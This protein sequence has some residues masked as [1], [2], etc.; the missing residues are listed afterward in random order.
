LLYLSV[1]LVLTA[2]NGREDIEQLLPLRMMRFRFEPVEA[3]A[4]V[5]GTEWERRL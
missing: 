2:T 4:V 3:A 5:I 1:Q